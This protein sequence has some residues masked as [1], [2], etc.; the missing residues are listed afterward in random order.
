MEKNYEED[1]KRDHALVK[2]ALDKNP[3]YAEAAKWLTERLTTRYGSDFGGTIS[4]DYSIID[5]KFTL[6]CGSEVRVFEED[7]IDDMPE[8]IQFLRKS[9]SK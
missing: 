5:N 7:Q 6:K 3:T 4:V 9:K 8:Q 1:A 2:E